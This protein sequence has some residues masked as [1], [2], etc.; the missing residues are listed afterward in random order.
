MEDLI[1]YVSLVL[2]VLGGGLLV[3][4]IG[5]TNEKVMK[6]LLAFSGAFLLGISFLH[7]VPEAYE[8]NARNAGIFILCGFLFQLLLEFFSEGIEHGHI[9]LHHGQSRFPVVIM[10]SLCIHAFVEGIPL[11]REIHGAQHL[12]H[13]HGDHSLLIGIVL[14]NIPVSLALMTMFLKSGLSVSKSLIWLMIFATMGP[15]GAFLGHFFG[16][17]I[18]L[19]WQDFFDITLA[20]VIGMFLHISTTILFESTEGHRFNL[21]KMIAIFLGVV[22]ALFNF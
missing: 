11:E 19:Y 6:I 15:L 20:I 13:D 4:W 16:A 8:S 14:H 2:S 3:L 5:S 1:I 21:V 17:E 7:L 9:H 18:S 12:G 10:I 22:M